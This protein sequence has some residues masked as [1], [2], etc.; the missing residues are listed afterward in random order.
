TKADNC[1]YPGTRDSLRQVAKNFEAL[2]RQAQMILDLTT[3]S[4][5]RGLEA[6][7][8]AQEHADEQRMN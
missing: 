4:D 5:E 3:Q 8:V 7:R 1:Q 6:R 2:A